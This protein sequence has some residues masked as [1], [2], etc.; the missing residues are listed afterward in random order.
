MLP[1]LTFVWGFTLDS[2]DP[3]HCR[4]TPSQLSCGSELNSLTVDQNQSALLE[5][6]GFLANTTQVQ[7]E[8]RYKGIASKA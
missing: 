7:R 6:R 4:S 5:G 1:V 2:D 8:K 3:V